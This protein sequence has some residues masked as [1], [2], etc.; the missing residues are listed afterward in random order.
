MGETISCSKSIQGEVFGY[1]AQLVLGTENNSLL[2][3]GTLKW[4]EKSPGEALSEMDETLADRIGNY[5]NRLLPAS[6][7]GEA[8]F[9]YQ[10]DTAVIKLDTAALLFQLV[11]GPDGK[12]L[13]F[14]FQTKET[15]GDGETSILLDALDAVADFFGVRTFYFYAQTGA[16]LGGLV[17][18]GVLKAVNGVIKGAMSLF[19]LN[20]IKLEASADMKQSYFNVE[21]EF[22][23]LGK[24]YHFKKEI[25]K[26]RLRRI[27]Q[28]S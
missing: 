5:V 15:F 25:G 1:P 3:A 20:Y 12:A 2:M 19:F 4:G 16:S 7:P 10:R 6:L 13:L 14:S 9:L 24:T 8:K 17:G 23:A 27:R 21:I 18:E 22:V 11:T 26:K 28:A